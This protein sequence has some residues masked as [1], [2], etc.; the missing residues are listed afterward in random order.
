M[1]HI[2]ENK[3]HEFRSS[4]HATTS[5]LR[6][7][8]SLITRRDIYLLTALQLPLDSSACV[9]VGTVLVGRERSGGV[10]MCG[11]GRGAVCP[12]KK[13]GGNSPLRRDSHTNQ[14]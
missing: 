7:I 12:A 8:L 1:L 2:G 11:D 6:L 13:R 5:L 10:W 3:G 4:S 9:A 14:L